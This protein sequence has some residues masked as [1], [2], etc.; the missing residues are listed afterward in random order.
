MASSITC[1]GVRPVRAISRMDCWAKIGAMSPPT[2]RTACTWP[3][4][5]S[6]S[7]SPIPAE[8]RRP[9]GCGCSQARC[10]RRAAALRGLVGPSSSVLPASALD[11]CSLVSPSKSAKMAA[12]AGANTTICAPSAR[13]AR[14]NSAAEMATDELGYSS[15]PRR[16]LMFG[17]NAPAGRRKTKDEGPRITDA[18]F[19]PSSFVVGQSRYA[20]FANPYARSCAI[21][22]ASPSSIM[23]RMTRPASQLAAARRQTS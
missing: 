19:G 17:M 14:A 21:S 4:V 18:R 16:C 10:A 22:S 3:G 2:V 5:A 13:F 9:S 20:F 23:P 1:C 8:V 7:R 15:R 11:A 6:P 12:P